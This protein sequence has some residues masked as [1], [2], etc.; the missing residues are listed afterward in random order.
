M[1]VIMPLEWRSGRLRFLDQT[2]LPFDEFYVETGEVE[3]IADAIRRLAIR[4][5]PLIGIAAAYAIAL[6][7]RA[8]NKNDPGDVRDYLSRASEMLA[9]TRPTA[10]NLFWALKRQKRIY[11]AWQG[12]AIGDLQERLIGEAK[13]IHREDAEMCEAMSSFGVKLLP[14]SV[15]ILTHC[16]TGSLATGG[17]GTAA[18]IITKAWELG[19]LKHVYIDETRPLLQGARLTAWE[20][21]KRNI[22]ATLI[23]DNAAAFLMQLKK[24]DAVIVGADRIAMN[25]DIANKIGTYGLAVAAKHHGIP[26]Y[27]AAPVSTID[28]HAE[29]GNAIPIE[30]RSEVEVTEIQGRKIAPPEIGVYAPAFDVTPNELI[31]AV[32]T[33]RGVLRSPFPESIQSLKIGGDRADQD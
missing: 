28:V 19:Q 22:P 30:E 6:A 24:I 25:G 33:D 11:S 2:R 9:S 17:R 20:M 3:V 1:N 18:G 4:G 27:V 21:N 5:A 29:S 26:F 10:V 7:G 32:V 15:T 8:I 16:N 31:S 12:G 14:S 23:V 13:A